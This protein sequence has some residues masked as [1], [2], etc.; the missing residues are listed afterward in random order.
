MFRMIACIA[1]LLV[2]GLTVASE[3]NSGVVPAQDTYFQLSDVYPSAKILAVPLRPCASPDAQLTVDSGGLNYSFNLNAEG[4]LILSLYSASPSL[5]GSNRTT[6][7]LFEWCGGEKIF[8]YRVN[9]CDGVC[10]RPP[11]KFP[12]SPGCGHDCVDMGRKG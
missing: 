11:L 3:V 7:S 2:S 10:A 9:V 12:H 4:G 5:V 1:A 8:Q 6:F